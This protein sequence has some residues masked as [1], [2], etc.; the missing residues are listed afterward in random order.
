[1]FKF[2]RSNFNEVGTAEN[3]PQPSEQG[4]KISPPHNPFFFSLNDDEDGLHRSRAKQ[5]EAGRSAQEGRGRDGAEDDEDPWRAHHSSETKL[6]RLQERSQQ[7]ANAAL[8]CGGGVLGLRVLRD[9]VWQSEKKQ[10]GQAALGGA[11]ARQGGGGPDPD[12]AESNFGAY[13]G[14][15][16]TY[17]T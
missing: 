9:F 13:A 2:W 3:D 14:A 17:R 11:D 8:L 5:E 1:M 6:R 4:N 7:L 12:G 15:V 10:P 16:Q